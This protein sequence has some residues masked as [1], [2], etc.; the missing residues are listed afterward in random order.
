VIFQVDQKEPSPSELV[1]LS[2]GHWKLSVHKKA[3]MLNAFIG[4]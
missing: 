4:C 2:N 1:S 3:M